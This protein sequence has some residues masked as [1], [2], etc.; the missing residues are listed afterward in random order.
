MNRSPAP[1]TDTMCDPL[2]TRIDLRSGAVRSAIDDDRRGS[3]VD[4]HSNPAM[5]RTSHTKRRRARYGSS[6][7]GILEHERSALELGL[8]AERRIAARQRVERGNCVARDNRVSLRVAHDGLRSRSRRAEP[9]GLFADE[10]RGVKE[11]APELQG[12]T[13]HGRNAVDDPRERRRDDRDFPREPTAFRFRHIPRAARGGRRRPRRAGGRRA[14]PRSP[15]R[16]RSVP[17]QTSTARAARRHRCSPATRD[18]WR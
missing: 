5:A 2:S 8:N 1:R 13:T 7:S 4:D 16:S 11:A 6:G 18:G 12:L 15:S 9:L 17:R 14:P 3:A 10:C